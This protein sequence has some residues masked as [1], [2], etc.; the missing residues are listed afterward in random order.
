[1]QYRVPVVLI[2]E[3][4]HG[5]KIPAVSTI[6]HQVSK[7]PG[8]THS[9]PVETVMEKLNETLTLIFFMINIFKSAN[10]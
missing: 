2:T 4:I 9:N 7:P 8:R 1:M 10:T 3:L 6:M 5:L